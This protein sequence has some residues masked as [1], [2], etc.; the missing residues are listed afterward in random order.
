MQNKNKQLYVYQRNAINKAFD[1]LITQDKPS[2]LI[3]STVGSGKT[4]M[5]SGTITE[6]LKYNPNFKFLVVVP[7]VTLVEQFYDT[8]HDD[9]GFQPAVLHNELKQ[10]KHGRRFHTGNS[11][12]II[13]MP[14]TFAGIVKGTSNLVLPK[15]WQADFIAMDEA[16]QNTASSSQAAR[17]YFPNCKVIGLTAS[18]RREQNKDGEHLWNWYEDRMIVAESTRNLINGGFIVEPKIMHRPTNSVVVDDWLKFIGVKE[19]KRTIIVT[20]DTGEAEQYVKQFEKEGVRVQIIT[21]GSDVFEVAGQTVATRQKYFKALEDGEL[22]VLVSVNSL[23][24]GFDCK[25]VANLIVTR[26]MQSISLMHQII[27]RV[28]R[29]FPGKTDALVLDYGNNIE[30]DNF[31]NKIWTYLDYAPNVISVGARGSITPGQLRKSRAAFACESCN[32]VYDLNVSAIC[33]ACGNIGRVQCKSTVRDMFCK[34]I[35][36]ETI[37][38]AELRELYKHINS[39]A[40]SVGNFKQ[41]HFER[42]NTRFFKGNRV[43]G[44]NAAPAFKLL[45][46]ALLAKKNVKLDTEIVYDSYE[47]V[48]VVDL[49][50]A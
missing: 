4:W 25:P 5:C 39:A 21:A 10:N 34:A 43:L 14:D 36:S 22:D 31:V 47:H 27:G 6:L 24:M 13:T 12:I 49:L 19:N 38:Q 17:D 32:H 20:T 30:F 33:Q 16:H 1:I 15:D 23:C 50:A 2:V 26:T 29:A 42:I 48:A 9:F 28:V 3:Q 18:P 44:N 46:E 37:D 11:N 7:S 35:N 40:T 45:G 41:G 8:L